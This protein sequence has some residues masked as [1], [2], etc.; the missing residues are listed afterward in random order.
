MTRLEELR[1]YSHGQGAGWA[2]VGILRANGFKVQEVSSYESLFPMVAAGRFDL[3]CRGANELLD[4]YRLHSTIPG[5][6]YDSSFA[7]VYPLPRFFFTSRENGKAIER[8]TRG[9]ELAYRDGSLQKL[10]EAQ[11]RESVDFAKLRSRRIFRLEN[12]L[13]RNIDFDFRK[14]DYDPLKD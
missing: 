4:E 3:L 7:L 13:I 12:P 2:D 14:Y 8:V 9:L 11:Y 10:W 5:F 1:R 6:A